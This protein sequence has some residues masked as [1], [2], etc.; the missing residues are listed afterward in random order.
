VVRF[1]LV[2]DLMRDVRIWR[3]RA[4]TRPRPVAAVVPGGVL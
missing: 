1:L 4:A 2:R 3:C